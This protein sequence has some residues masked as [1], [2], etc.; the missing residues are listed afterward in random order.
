[1]KKLTKLAQKRLSQ[2]TMEE[3]QAC[4]KQISRRLDDNSCYFC[5]NAQKS[6]GIKPKRRK[7]SKWQKCYASCLWVIMENQGCTR[8]SILLAEKEIRWN[9]WLFYLHVELIRR[10]LQG[11]I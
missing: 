4:E 7:T 2:L 3:I 9:R 6:I 11:E 1:M 10:K 8:N 5:E